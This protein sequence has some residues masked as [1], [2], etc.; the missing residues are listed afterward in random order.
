MN[1]KIQ[2]GM[3]GRFF[4][5]NWRPA[6]EEIDFARAAG[7]ESIQFPGPP[8]GLDAKR[9]GDKMAVVGDYLR[10]A[11]ITP[12]MEL[13]IHV[14]GNGRTAKGKAPIEE[15]H[16]NL[17]AILALGCTCVH[18][19]I[20]LSDKTVLEAAQVQMEEK[21]IPQLQEAV[22][23]AE[24]HGF[25]FGLEHNEPEIALFPTPERCA[26]VL[27]AVP[28]LGFVWDLNH[29]IPKHVTGFKA[30]A[31]RVSM[32]HVSDTPL[33]EVNHHLPLGQGNVNFVNY[34]RILLA[35]GFTG[36]A[37]LEIGG[38]PKSGGYGQDTDEALRDS[39]ERLEKA[40]NAVFTTE[41]T[42]STEI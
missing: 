34:A 41:G 29:T 11:G 2:I 25:R 6:R 9:L 21:L 37:I 35:A 4:P 16:A 23:V 33:P 8:G 3:N 39:R 17:P 32:V 36:L 22:E 10:E 1:S 14:W 5:S 15:L 42:E 27:T 20:V 12:V 26:Q 28:Q 40:L 24:R 38:L 30:L 19:H 13:P 31:D 18:W 7:F